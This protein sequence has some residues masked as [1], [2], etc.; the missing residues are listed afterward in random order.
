ME[1]RPQARWRHFLSDSEDGRDVRAED[2][3]HRLDRAREHY[4]KVGL[5]ADYVKN[6]VR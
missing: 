4:E 3:F 6:F 1:R 2:V 5:G